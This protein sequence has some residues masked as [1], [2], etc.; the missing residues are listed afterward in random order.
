LNITLVIL[1]VLIF[2]IYSIYAMNIITGTPWRFEAEL[3][4]TFKY[5]LEEKGPGVKKQIIAA[6]FLSLII[7]IGYFYLVLNVINNWLMVQFTSF[8]IGLEV[9]H[10][11]KAISGFKKLFTGLIEVDQVFNWR[12]ERISAMAFFTHSLLIILT[13][14][15]FNTAG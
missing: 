2:I 3:L 7:E 4:G 11:Y 1:A 10:L 15:F 8:F 9:I 6:V 14:I 12:L 5:W 13:I